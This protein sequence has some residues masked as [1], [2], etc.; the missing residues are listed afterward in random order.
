MMLSKIM[1]FMLHDCRAQ[2]IQLS[3]EALVIRDYIELERLR[4][5]DRLIVDYQENIDNP[6]ELIAPL[7]LLPFVENSFKHGASSTM[8][9][10][11][12]LVHLELIRQQLSFKVQ[13]TIDEDSP[14][15][16]KSGIGL[17][18]VQRQLELLYP[19]KY[20]LEFG[21]KQGQYLVELKID[22]SEA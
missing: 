9:K 22:L 21:P 19:G 5:N 8:G 14:K 16:G 7:M 18:N 6:G 10:V 3:S 2:R 17:S 13:N 11:E 12:I 4:Y 1:R 20:T 15:N